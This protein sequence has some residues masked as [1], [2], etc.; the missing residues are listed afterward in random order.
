MKNP[1]RIINLTGHIINIRTKKGTLIRQFKPYPKKI[2]LNEVKERVGIV[3]GVPLE[4]VS[5][6]RPDWLPTAKQ[7]TYYIVG[8]IVKAFYPDRDDFL[9][10]CTV[11]RNSK[12]YIDGVETLG[13]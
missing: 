1:T 5:Y 9:V 7:G 6:A 12:G 11:V 3:D 2:M 4:K 10:P 13:F 8:K